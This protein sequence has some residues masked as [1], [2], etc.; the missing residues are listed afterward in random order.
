M[1]GTQNDWQTLGNSE[2]IGNKIIDK[3]ELPRLGLWLLSFSTALILLIS[4][5]IPRL[6][7]NVV[8]FQAQRMSQIMNY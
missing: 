7:L 8:P 6:T 4:Q 2:C 3:R 1:C 5:A